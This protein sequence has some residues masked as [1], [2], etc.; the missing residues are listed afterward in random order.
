MIS[1]VPN[2]QISILRRDRIEIELLREAITR[3]RI[4]RLG[5]A[6]FHLSAMRA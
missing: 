5:F 3:I 1:T 6:R 4:N 2:E